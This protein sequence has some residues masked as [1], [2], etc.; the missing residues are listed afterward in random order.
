MQL[1]AVAEALDR[2]DALALGLDRDHQAGSAR[3]VIEDHGTCPAHA[4][5]TPDMRPGQST[6]VTDDVDKCSSRLDPNGIVM[7]V[8]V[9]LELEL[10]THRTHSPAPPATPC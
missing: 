3:L 2:A 7:A 9:E 4:V 8:D 1:V 10:V 5:L 6:F